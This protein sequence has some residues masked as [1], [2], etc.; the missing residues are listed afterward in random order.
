MQL[1]KLLANVLILYSACYN[2]DCFLTIHLMTIFNTTYCNL[3]YVNVCTVHLCF[4]IRYVI[5]KYF[6]KGPILFS[7]YLI[8]YT[9]IWINDKLDR[10]IEHS[11]FNKID[12]KIEMHN[13]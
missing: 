7:L 11:H 10:N 4:L 6:P 8:I 9:I 1:I 5:I 13:K 3:Y 2:S 12:E